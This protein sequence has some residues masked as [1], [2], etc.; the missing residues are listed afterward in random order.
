MTAAHEIPTGE[1][2]VQVALQ[3]WRPAGFDLDDPTAQAA[4]AR[5]RDIVAA[6]CPKTAKEARQAA[7][8]RL[9]PMP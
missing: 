1:D 7:P 4:L 3:R 9:P 6:A 2:P 8:R 5:S